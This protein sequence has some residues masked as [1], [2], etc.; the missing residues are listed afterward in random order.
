MHEIQLGLDMDYASII[1]T[2]TWLKDLE[3]YSRIILGK[4]GTVLTE[5]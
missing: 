1:L 5:L 2:N 4:G 3:N